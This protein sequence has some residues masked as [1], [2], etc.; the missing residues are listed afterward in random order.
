MRGDLDI[1]RGKMAAQACHASLGSFKKTEALK[2]RK[3]EI[4]GE[5]KVILQ[6]QSL[7]ELFEIYEI[8]K[9]S[10][11]ATYLVKDAG[12]TELPSSTVTCLA[13][14]P[15]VDEKIDKITGDLKL[16]K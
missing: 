15:D 4:E 14:G 16:L 9:K 2:L 1:S 11:T 8:A 12:L 7:K 6:V 13:I 10:D 5:K 3:W